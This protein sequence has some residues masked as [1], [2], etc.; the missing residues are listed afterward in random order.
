MSGSC[1][2]AGPGLRTGAGCEIRN[3]RHDLRRG[4]PLFAAPRLSLPAGN[5]VVL[6]GPSGSGK[7]TLLYL[8]A[9]LLTPAQGEIHWDGEEITRLS[10]SGRDAWRRRR[11]GF[12]FQDFHLVPELSPLE[13]VLVPAWFGSFS[14]RG[15]RGR[16]R[17]LLA[18]FGVPERARA[19]LLSRGEQQRVALARALLT[20][21][22]VIFADEP[23]AS[24]D[25]TAGA[26]V[27]QALHQLARGGQTVIAASHDPGLIALA[28]LRLV[29]ARGQ[30]LT[31]IT[32]ALI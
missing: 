25:T 20:E 8:L 10:E 14:A 28:D 15:S 17:E 3:L 27:A 18:G 32:E 16:A 7:S 4:E 29:L 11:A 6:T 30:P 5:L 23:T 2:D 24:L 22:S 12:V 9:G 31:A 21:P 1:F 13:N 19:G 26:G